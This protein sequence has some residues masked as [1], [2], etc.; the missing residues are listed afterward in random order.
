[1]RYGFKIQ[2]MIER[3]I[4]KEKI[5]L[6][7]KELQNDPYVLY[8]CGKINKGQALREIRFMYE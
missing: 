1:M 2:I 5:K 6:I 4:E 3:M 7:I 8:L